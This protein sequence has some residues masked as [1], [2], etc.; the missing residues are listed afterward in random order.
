MMT[1][2]GWMSIPAIVVGGFRRAQLLVQ[3]RFFRL[4]EEVADRV[5]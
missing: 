4:V 5:E 3:A 1:A 2:T